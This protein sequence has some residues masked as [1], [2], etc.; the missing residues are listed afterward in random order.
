[1][2]AKQIHRFVERYL[3]AT[4]C[5]ILEK[6]PAHFK[7]KLSPAADRELTNRPYY[8]SFVD[9]TGAEPETMSLLL[10]TDA[11]KYDAMTMEAEAA[12][13]G[14]QPGSGSQGATHSVA[15]QSVATPSV[16][17][18]SVAAHSV[19]APSV[20]AQ[21]G[22]A[23]QAG[24]AALSRS[25]GFVPAGLGA[26]T[27]RD[28]LYF[29]SRRL[30][31]LFAATRRGGRF[32]CLFQQPDE[33]ALH[34]YDS[35]PYTPWLG[36]NVKVGFV[37]DMKR[38]EMHAFGVS[39]ATGTVVERFFDRLQGLKLTPRLPANVHVAGAALTLKKAADL[40][41]QALMQKLKTCDYGW[42]AAANRRLAEE[43]AQLAHYYEPLIESADDKRRE[44]IAAQYEARKE[45]IV[46]QLKPRVVIEA[47]N[48]GLF[49]LSGLA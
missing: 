6:S 49:H 44:Q 11:A 33:R 35:A 17:A 38:E 1:M 14:R 36:V 42:A 28:D 15:A 7:V 47:V 27:P 8:W 39:L 3:E 41:E 29:G 34:P 19:A 25:F 45:E 10:V 2:N 22:T 12:G 46:W 40:V 18:P 31:Q 21:G 24:M 9:R 37:C 26:R 20:A 48:A 23:E 30:E 13:A 4:G 5:A 16:A 32:V 43:L